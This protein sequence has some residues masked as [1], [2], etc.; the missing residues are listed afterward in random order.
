MY[1]KHILTGAYRKQ[2]P[3]IS[4]V[5]R[6][7]SVSALQMTEIIYGYYINI[8]APSTVNTWTYCTYRTNLFSKNHSTI[9]NTVIYTVLIRWCGPYN[10]LANPPVKSSSTYLLKQ[11]TSQCSQWRSA[12]AF[13]NAKGTTWCW[14]NIVRRS[15]TAMKVSSGVFIP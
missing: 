3:N 13:L 7:K 9:K 4:L 11:Y 12:I 14:T 10:V 8:Y 6:R 15:G 1:I 5:A 2:F